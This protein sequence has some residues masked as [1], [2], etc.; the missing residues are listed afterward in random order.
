MKK[1]VNRSVLF[2]SAMLMTAPYVFAASTS[3]S[4]QISATVEPVLSLNIALFDEKNMAAEVP[5]I[6]FGALVR[7]ASNGGSPAAFRSGSN[8]RV[9][10]GAQT[11]G[12][13]FTITQDMTPLTSGT[14]T[15]PD[16]IVCAPVSHFLSQGGGT[17]GPAQSSRTPNKLI[18]TSDSSGQDNAVEVVCGISNGPAPFAGWQPI[19]PDQ[20]AGTYI[21]T[22]TLTLTTN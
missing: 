9:F 17:L 5:S 7:P 6:A 14:N 4:V 2:T 13:P 20:P 19:P 18:F 21:G 12:K 3:Q 1:T 11:S 22:A 10:V 16:A 8:I 15:L